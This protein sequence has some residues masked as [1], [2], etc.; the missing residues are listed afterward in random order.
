MTPAELTLAI[1]TTWLVGLL[2]WDAY[3]YLDG[4][5]RNSVTQVVID[6]TKSKSWGWIFPFALGYLTGHLY[7]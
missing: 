4:K 5:P 6:Y 3:L 7:G 1:F 2:L